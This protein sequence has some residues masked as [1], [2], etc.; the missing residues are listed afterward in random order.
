MITTSTT[1]NTI[2][3]DPSHYAETK[4]VVGDTT[5]DE[6]TIMA[7]ERTQTL[8]S[9]YYDIGNTVINQITFTL[10]GVTADE[11]P[12][13]SRVEVWTRIKNATLTSEWIPM[14]VY[15]TMKPTYDTESQILEVVGYD[16]MY[17]TATVPFEQGVNLTAWDNPNIRQVAEHLT[18]GTVVTDV[19]DTNFA[20]IGI[21]LEDPTQIPTGITMGSTPFNFTVREILTDIAIASCGNWLI[22]FQD[23]GNGG[24]VSKLRLIRNIDWADDGIDVLIAQNGDAITFGGDRILV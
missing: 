2:F 21:A 23:D 17:K 24:Q 10:I 22:V 19:I 4:I 5:Y 14:G 6:N 18:S 11:L 15:Y 1:Y 7:C 9:G 13:M 12:R 3:A 8:F 20:G 16:E